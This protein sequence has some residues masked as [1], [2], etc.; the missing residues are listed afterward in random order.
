MGFFGRFLRLSTLLKS[1]QNCKSLFLVCARTVEL[2]FLC[3]E[4]VEKEVFSQKDR[5]T[6]KKKKMKKTKKETKSI[7]LG[8]RKTI[9]N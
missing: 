4:V 5:A 6:R 1:R 8:S 2:Q 9:D 7:K 3:G